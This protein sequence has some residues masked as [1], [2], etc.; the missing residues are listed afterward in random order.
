MKTNNIPRGQLISEWNEHFPLLTPYGPISLMI[1][2]DIFLIGIRIERSIWGGDSFIPRLT[3]NALW[4]K[5]ADGSF[6]RLI[7]QDLYNKKHVHYFFN[8][9]EYRAY[10]KDILT[11][12]NEQFGFFF[13]EEVL[14]SDFF[15]YLTWYSSY[16][17]YGHLILSE[18]VCFYQ[19]QLALA[20]YINDRQ[21]IELLQR[22][23]ERDCKTWNNEQFHYIFGEDISDWKAKQYVMLAHRDS[24]LA[25]VKDNC[26]IPKIG[27]L[28]KG[29]II[30]DC[31]KVMSMLKK[32]ERKEKLFSIFRLNK[33][34]RAVNKTMKSLVYI[35]VSLLSLLSVSA[36]K[37]PP[38]P[39]IAEGDTVRVYTSPSMDV[40]AS[41]W[42]KDMPHLTLSPEEALEIGTLLGHNSRW[43]QRSY[44]S[45][46]EGL[47]VEVRPQKG[48][49]FGYYMTPKGYT[50]E[51]VGELNNTYSYPRMQ[52]N[53]A[54]ELIKRYQQKLPMNSK[55]CRYDHLPMTATVQRPIAC[56]MCPGSW[57]WMHV[58][59][60]V[61]VD[62]FRVKP[63]DYSVYKKKKE[64]SLIVSRSM[65]L[66]WYYGKDVF[67]ENIE[68][69]S[70]ANRMILK[71]IP[72]WA[73][74]TWPERMRLLDN[75]IEK[76]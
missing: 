75:Y 17:R 13:K 37:K 11:C 7:T 45:Y 63:M 73:T 30:N 6:E 23:L 39:T 71:L 4:S 57:N 32:K 72:E 31:E 22:S 25:T 53:M 54:K 38:L 58:C 5:N 10:S 28:K 8:S 51:V 65:P 69:D 3:I 66:L 40:L 60:L 12:A 20:L 49:P 74:M 33:L 1:K 41:N 24:F 52:K 64:D 44:T 36:Q 61:Q 43:S 35:V 16:C 56:M 29:H 62:S 18:Q 9:R 14:L 76:N 59:F 19:I 34:L 70:I 55:L 15:K 42:L 27:N 2:L 67:T 47:F 26:I 68:T 46:S 48:K 50:P 21:L